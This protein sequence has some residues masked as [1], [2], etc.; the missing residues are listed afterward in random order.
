MKNLLKV[1]AIVGMAILGCVADSTAQVQQSITFSLTVYNQSDSGVR[2]VRVGTKDVIEHL[3]GTSV[4][5]G[6]LWLVM[7][8]DPG[9]DGY[10]TIGAFLRVTDSHGNIMVETRTDSFNLYETSFSQT[11]THTYAW[12]NFSLSFGGLGAELYGTAIWSKSPRG[13][14]GQGTFHCKVSGH[15]GL[16]GITDGQEP[17]GGSVS[18][19]APRP[20]G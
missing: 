8:N 4:P 20:T 18:G 11:T 12:N 15:C 2:I 6:H 9:L 1:L 16:T 17:C 10:G 5:G 13:P 3:A 19:S 7:A 14:G